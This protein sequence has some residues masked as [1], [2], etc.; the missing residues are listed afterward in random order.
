M[1]LLL[2]AVCLADDSTKASQRQELHKIAQGVIDARE[3]GVKRAAADGMPTIAFG[4]HIE[5]RIDE[6]VAKGE[7][8]GE[9]SHED[10]VI[11]SDWLSAE[12]PGRVKDMKHRLLREAL[13]K[14]AK[15]WNKETGL[16]AIVKPYSVC[17]QWNAAEDL[18]GDGIEWSVNKEAK[19]HHWGHGMLAKRLAQDTE[20]AIHAIAAN[21]TFAASRGMPDIGV[22]L[23][24]RL[25][26]IFATVAADGRFRWTQ[27]IPMNSFEFALKYAPCSAWATDAPSDAVA[28]K[29]NELLYEAFKTA[30]AEW[31]NENGV[32]LHVSAYSP[33][34]RL[35][36][37]WR[38]GECPTI[39]IPEYNNIYPTNRLWTT[40]L[41]NRLPF[42]YNQYYTTLT[43]ATTGHNL[44]NTLELTRAYNT[45]AVPLGIHVPAPARDFYAP[46][47]VPI[48]GKVSCEL[49]PQ[50]CVQQQQ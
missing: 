14:G 13:V 12:K 35:C 45:L 41:E 20:A 4:A 19:Q 23:R 29:R 43:P 31:N 10:F 40:T 25:P 9:S 6:A 33:V 39:F 7:Y 42:M 11:G 36:A 8:R 32:R 26:K 48:P 47:G 30:V 21:L 3:A 34:I 28:K 18:C 37:E 24:N 2:L 27:D 44:F 22:L 1:L 5:K 15:E 49:F 50:A 17:V 38:D 16:Y 46:M